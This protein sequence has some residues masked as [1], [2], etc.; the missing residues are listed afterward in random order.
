MLDLDASSANP[1]YNILKRLSAS[2]TIYLDLK[3]CELE[4]CNGSLALA[5]KSCKGSGEEV[6]LSF[7][8]GLHLALNGW[9]GR[10][11]SLQ[12][13]VG[14]PRVSAKPAPPCEDTWR[15]G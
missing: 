12:V 4:Q 14:L 8:L 5:I 15:I 11:W 6:G 13:L 7:S 2:L 9:L 3:H 1:M 10:K